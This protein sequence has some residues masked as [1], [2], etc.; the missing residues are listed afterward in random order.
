MKRS[1]PNYI[2]DSV[3]KYHM[4]VVYVS[5]RSQRCDYNIHN[6]DYFVDDTISHFKNEIFC[7]ENSENYL[8]VALD[9]LIEILSRFDLLVCRWSIL[10]WA[11]RITIDLLLIYQINA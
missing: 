9:F 1:G 10:S 11:L 2:R 7:S 6:I 5:P 4:Q 3:K 8:F